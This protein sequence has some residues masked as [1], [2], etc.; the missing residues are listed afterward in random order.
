MNW[1]REDV[2]YA[3]A[4]A[5]AMVVV[6]A[7][8]AGNFGLLP[9][10]LPGVDREPVDDVA[11]PVVAAGE[12]TTGG[13]PGGEPAG[14]TDVD[15][16]ASVLGG[17]IPAGPT[18]PAPPPAPAPADTTPPDTAF[19]T[20]DGEIMTPLGGTRVR[21]TVTDDGSGVGSVQVTFDGVLTSPTPKPASVSCEGSERRRCTWEV[22]PPA[23]A[24][25]YTVSAQSTDRAGNVE[26]PG[27]DPIQVTI[28]TAE[29][30]E[31]A[32]GDTDEG[33]GLLGS[34]LERAKGLLGL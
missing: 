18:A 34:L 21:G 11:V 14:G 1:T 10:P 32:D 19:T 22:A 30:D 9:S 12:P 15:D 27:P 33:S 24:D 20:E 28:V 31:R 13:A 17:V 29:P 25:R 4:T 2:R 8:A 16:A 3:V 5:A 23:R 7:L 26:S 6:V